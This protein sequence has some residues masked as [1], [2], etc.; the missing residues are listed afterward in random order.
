MRYARCVRE[1]L[2]PVSVSDR[3]LFGVVHRRCMD[4]TMQVQ[5]VSVDDCVYSKQIQYIEFI[6]R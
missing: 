5:V 2:V 3:T 4:V 6:Y 1:A